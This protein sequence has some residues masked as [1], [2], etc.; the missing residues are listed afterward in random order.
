[1][2]FAHTLN[3][4][5]LP[6]NAFLAMWPTLTHPQGLSDSRTCALFMV[7]LEIEDGVKGRR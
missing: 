7:S 3:A 6:D 1:M 5:P 2:A 4:I